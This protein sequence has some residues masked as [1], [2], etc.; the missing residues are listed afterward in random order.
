ML[1]IIADWKSVKGMLNDLKIAVKSLISKS[2]IYHP[3]NIMPLP[4]FAK[5]IPENTSLNAFD[6]AV[7]FGILNQPL[8][9][10]SA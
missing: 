8:Q 9:G 7:E 3:R 10:L 2:L 5:S 1:S 6:V 4:S